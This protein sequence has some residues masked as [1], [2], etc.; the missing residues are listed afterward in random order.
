MN[1]PNPRPLP[2]A[3]LFHT[4]LRRLARP[5]LLLLALFTLYRAV[6][7]FSFFRGVPDDFVPL[8]RRA[9]VLGY[10]DF[11]GSVHCHSHHS[12]DSIGTFEEIGEAARRVGL[13]FVLITDHIA[14]RSV[15]N[16]V[17][18]AKAFHSRHNRPLFIIGAEIGSVQHGLLAFP[19]TQEVT[20]RHTHPAKTIRAI[21]KQGGVAFISHAEKYLRWDE[22]PM[23]GIEIYNLHAAERETNRV[24][25]IISAL[26]LP[27][28][29]ML[30]TLA[31]PPQKNFD[32]WNTL[33]KDRKMPVVGSG[34]AHA[35]HWM[36]IVGGT[37]VG[38]YE[39][40]FK[41]VTTHVFAK[42]RD[43]ASIVE[44]LKRG[45]SYVAFDIWR[46]ATGFQFTAAD[47][48][49]EWMMGDEISA[50]ENVT[51]NVKLPAPADIRLLK[52]GTEIASRHGDS[53][54][55]KDAAAGVYRVET[56]L[57]GKLW[58]ISNPIYV[59]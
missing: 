14:H 18:E 54:T 31:A 49:N 47:G 21:H 33:L 58:I 28:R 32:R 9:P 55:H 34:D 5:A 48:A 26:I 19:L 45:R 22:T 10:R 3:P 20:D 43:E 36:R 40:I 24:G 7:A 15:E 16:G 6:V 29:Q 30:Q 56:Y 23:D 44:A 4:R 11:K 1:P 57:N 37:T 39:R 51:L 46:D 59:R 52:D 27:P 35:Q 42:E 8:E 50:S 41:V 38:I 25:L 53:Y 13:D 12:H 2:A 17:A